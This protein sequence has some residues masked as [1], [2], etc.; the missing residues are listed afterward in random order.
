MTNIKKLITDIWTS[1]ESAESGSLDLERL[2]NVGERIA[3]ALEL[4]AE[5]PESHI[6]ETGAST[7]LNPTGGFVA[8]VQ[9]A[10]RVHPNWPL[11]DVV[12][13]VRLEMRREQ[14]VAIEPMMA[15]AA[16]LMRIPMTHRTDA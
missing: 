11:I 7:S 13:H 14:D 6:S 9:N 4:I 8:R 2:I 12:A 5:A 16:D 1:A 3:D 15:E 10:R